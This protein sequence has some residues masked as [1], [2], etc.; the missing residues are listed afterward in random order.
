MGAELF[1]VKITISDYDNNNYEIGYATKLSIK[2]NRD[3]NTVNTFSG[4]IN[5]IAGN[6]T[7][8]ELSLESVS[9]AKSVSD[10]IKLENMLKNGMIKSIICSGK[11]YTY[12]GDVY[13]RT[14][15][16]LNCVVTT[17]EEDWSPSDG[18]TSKLDFSAN[19]IIKDFQ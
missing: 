14:I 4:D 3:T 5:T 18:V 16:G 6:Q 9:W 1:Q 2:R 10:M 7:G 17:D 12:A 8:G 19:E 15:T 13:S 11:G